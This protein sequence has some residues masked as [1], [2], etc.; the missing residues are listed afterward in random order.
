[1]RPVEQ[2]EAPEGD[3]DQIRFQPVMETPQVLETQTGRGR[4]GIDQGD[5]VAGPALQGAQENISVGGETQFGQVPGQRHGRLLPL[6]GHQHFAPEKY[7]PPGWFRIFIWRIGRDNK[8]FFH[9]NGVGGTQVIMAAKIF[10]IFLA[11]IKNTAT[12]LMMP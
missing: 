2:V 7:K 11:V 1:M 10:E 12:D 9:S 4:R 8:L 3:G 6:G 5:G